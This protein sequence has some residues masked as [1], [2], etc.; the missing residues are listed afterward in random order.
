MPDPREDLLNVLA[1]LRLEKQDD[2]KQYEQALKE[3]SLFDRRAKGTCWYPLEIKETGYSIG[4][5][6]YFIADRTGFKEVPHQFQ[7][8]KMVSFFSNQDYHKGEAVKGTVNYVDGDRIKVVLYA[9]ELPEWADDGKIGIDL[10]FDEYTYKTME[11]AL[12][13]VIKA[14]S[15]RLAYLRDVLFGVKV[16]QT[17]GL[18]NYLYGNGLNQSQNE[19]VKAILDAEDVALVHGPPGTG[20]TTTLVAA[21]QQIAK[22]EKNILVCA[23]SNAAVDLLTERL[24]AKGLNVVRIGNLSRI[25]D[26]VMS[27]TLDYLLGT[28]PSM[29]DIK[30]M[31]KQADEYRRMAGKYKRHFG[32]EE[33]E[34][35]DALYKEAR[36]VT[37]AA[38]NMEEQMVQELLDKADVIACTLVGALH[39][40]L[41]NR[42]FKTAIIDEAAQALEPAAW[43]PITLCE[44]IVLA[45][46]PFQLPPTVRSKDAQAKGLDKTLL[47]K[48]MQR[49]PQAHL[50]NVQ[51]RMNQTIMGFSNQWFYN[52]QLQ[53]DDG[54]ANWSLPDNAAIEFID[55]AGCGFEEQMEPVSTSLYNEGEAGVVAKRLEGLYHQLPAGERQLEVGVISPYREQV[56]WLQQH[57]SGSDY[58]DFELSINTIDSFQGQERDVVVISLVRSNERNEIGF[59]SDYRRMNVAITRAKKKL[60]VI[61][62]S[63]TL[64]NDPFYASFIEYVEQNGSYLSAWEYV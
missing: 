47:E 21:I 7:A 26:A 60:I 13:K 55:T 49:L 51:Y 40:Y 58:P 18:R 6:P 22:E 29:K 43:I 27:H 64:T 63:G 54:V 16:P 39:G 48:A 33:R 61:G 4:E 46:D 9:D 31:R 34:Q 37:R 32:K 15:G 3:Q 19:A 1:L 28:H 14:E 8:G 45:G 35:R 10:L 2:L 20:K 36:T 25:D 24:A 50:L 53:A 38:A 62:D 12:E 56:I 57:L 59:L 30:Q 5:Y 42:K 17:I 41:A 44:R 52:N 11:T 23:P